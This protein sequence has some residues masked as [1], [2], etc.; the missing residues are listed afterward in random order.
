LTQND[1]PNYFL[2]RST[3]F[4]LT[5]FLAIVSDPKLYSLACCGSSPAGIVQP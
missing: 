4:P 3:T 2:I 5:S 1:A